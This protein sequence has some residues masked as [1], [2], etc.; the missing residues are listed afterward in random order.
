MKGVRLSD[1]V[2]S[3]LHRLRGR[4]AQNSRRFQRVQVHWI[5][6]VHNLRHL[7]GLCAHLL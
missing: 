5:H 6:H 3:P 1:P 2:D 7:A 4:H